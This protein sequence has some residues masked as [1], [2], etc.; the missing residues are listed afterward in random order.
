MQTEGQVYLRHRNAT[1]PCFNEKVSQLVWAESIRQAR[2][3]LEDWTSKA[4]INTVAADTRTLSLHVLSSAGFGKSYPFRSFDDSAPAEAA[5]SYRGSL[6]LILDDCVPLVVL[7]RKNLDRWYRWLPARWKALHQATVTFRQY[8][9]RVYEEEQRNLLENDKDSSNLVTSLIRASNEMA[10]DTSTGEASESKS[11]QGGLTEEEI[12]GNMFIFSFAGHDTTAHVLAFAIV[13]LSTRPDVQDWVAEELQHVLTE[14]PEAV[15]ESYQAIF[16]RLKR[17]L[18]VLV[19]AQNNRSTDFPPKTAHAIAMKE[20]R[21]RKSPNR[22]STKPS[23][24]TPPR[25]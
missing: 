11:S 8:M 12:Y 4:S 3:M 10:N 15:E 23:A 19:R 2:G 21:L 5:S 17:C 24:C 16:P 14:Q 1:I 22:N 9:K 7:G 6:K 18:A 25:R 20:K 13:L